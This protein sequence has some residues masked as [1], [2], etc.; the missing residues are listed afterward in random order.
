MEIRPWGNA[1]KVYIKQKQ[2]NK[3]ADDSDQL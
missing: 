3:D 1:K 2:Q